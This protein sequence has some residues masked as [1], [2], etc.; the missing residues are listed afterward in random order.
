MSIRIKVTTRWGECKVVPY[1]FSYHNLSPCLTTTPATGVF[2]N[3][4]C[5]WHIWFYRTRGPT[6]ITQWSW[7]C[8]AFKFKYLFY[9]FHIHS[10]N[11]TLNSCVS[12]SVPLLWHK[13]SGLQQVNLLIKHLS[14]ELIAYTDRKVIYCRHL[15]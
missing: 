4:Q 2:R 6:T 10:A 12:F 11:T 5:S 7:V 14:K 3:G 1:V 8:L 13:G 9:K 15:S